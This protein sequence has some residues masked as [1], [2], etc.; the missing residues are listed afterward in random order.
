MKLKLFECPS[1]GADLHVKAS[2]TEI[3]CDYC[4]QH[5]IVD[6]PVAD[7][8]E[9]DNSSKKSKSKA[10]TVLILVI[11][12]FVGLVTIAAILFKIFDSDE[13]DNNDYRNSISSNVTVSSEIS[14]T[15][16]EKDYYTFRSDSVRQVNYENH[17]IE[18]GFDSAV[19]YEAGANKVIT[20][21]AT[22]TRIASD[23]CRIYYNEESNFYVKLHEDGAIY[24]FFS[25]VAGKGFFE[26]N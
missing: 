13:S 8:V 2:T 7:I 3:K 1:C 5:F 22:L 20:D 15:A 24:L 14:I 16:I 17:G 19:A 23:G 18:M 26:N 9:S 25:P 10:E 6:S 21:P 11:A 12:V 4:G